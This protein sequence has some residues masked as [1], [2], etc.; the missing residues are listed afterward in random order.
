MELLTNLV[1]EAIKHDA[2]ECGDN[3]EFNKGIAAI[4]GYIGQDDGGLASLFFEDDVFESWDKGIQKQRIVILGQY[5]SFELNYA[6]NAPDKI[7]EIDESED[8]FNC[9]EKLPQDVKNVVLIYSKLFE[10][11][12]YDSYALCRFFQAEM[13]KLGHWCDYDLDGSPHSLRK[14]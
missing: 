7:T 5:I 10:E 2:G 1:N 12:E 8:L 14:L 6:G 9:Q 3:E 4:Q 13:K 11:S